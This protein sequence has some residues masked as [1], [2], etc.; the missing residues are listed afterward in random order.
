MAFPLF[1]LADRIVERRTQLRSRRAL[2]EVLSDPHLA[3]DLGLPYQ[4]REPRR[5]EQW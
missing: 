1:S 3:R 4:P 2:K 5:P